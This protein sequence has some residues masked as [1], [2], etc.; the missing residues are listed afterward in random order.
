VCER[1]SN[2]AI[3]YAPTLIDLKSNVKEYFPVVVKHDSNKLS[4]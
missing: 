3:G 4:F 1:F 2:R